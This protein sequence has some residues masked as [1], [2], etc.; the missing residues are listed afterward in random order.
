[1]AYALCS[2]LT[3]LIEK[4]LSG[5]CN[6]ISCAEEIIYTGAI[7]HNSTTEII[8]PRI[9]DFIQE[10]TI[11]YDNLKYD[12]LSK[13]MLLNIEMAYIETEYYTYDNDVLIQE[14]MI[15]RWKMNVF[16]VDESIKLICDYEV[17]LLQPF[18]VTKLVLVTTKS[19]N[20]LR[21]NITSKL[22]ISSALLQNKKIDELGLENTN[23]LSIGMNVFIIIN[24][25]FV[26][27]NNRCKLL[28]GKI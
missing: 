14:P 19:K 7:L 18:Q 8:I 20:L 12:N 16:M 1:M 11:K 25:C 22:K 9:G 24:Y 6:P 17:N 5:V 2:G 23:I 15:N 10:I 3:K 4:E 13:D 27:I 26:D 21:P 28:G